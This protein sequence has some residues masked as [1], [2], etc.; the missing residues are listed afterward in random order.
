MPSRNPSGERGNWR[1]RRQTEAAL[2]ESEE[3]YRLLA[4][5][6]S[7]V[8]WI[9]DLETMRFRYVSPSVERLR[10]YTAEEVL[11]ADGGESVMPPSL[12]HIQQVV[13]GRLREAMQ[14]LS[15]G[16]VDEIEQPGKDGST[17][18]T[19]VTTHYF[20]NQDQGHWEAYG[21]SRD[22]TERKQAEKAL[23]K[24]KK[25]IADWWNSL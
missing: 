19:E 18:W 5:N 14:G 25:S 6:I 9:L 24:V 11:A 3:H 22:I 1:E 12:Q 23:R 15:K 10:G 8:I 13:P 2:R 21:V 20:L 16:Y 17:V 7:D 4:E